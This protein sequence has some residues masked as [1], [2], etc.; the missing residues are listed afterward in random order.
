MH[1]PTS[2]ISTRAEND[3]SL[4]LFSE[5]DV[6][7]SEMSEVVVNNE[8]YQLEVLQVAMEELSS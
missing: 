4:T 1:P 6:V 2:P 5:T 7:Q 3:M 8:K